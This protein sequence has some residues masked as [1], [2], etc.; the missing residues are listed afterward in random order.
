MPRITYRLMTAAAVAAIGLG[1]VA[2]GTASAEPTA[3][4]DQA[5]VFAARSTQ[6]KF[7]NGTGCT[8]TRA[9]HGLSHGIWSQEPPAVVYN[10]NDAEW[11]SESNGFMTGTEGSVKFTTSDCEEGWRS[12]RVIRFHWNNPYVGGNGYDTDGTDGSFR[13]VIEGGGGNNAVVR[14]GEYKN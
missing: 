8:L 9:D 6:V 3:S 2:A 12:G 13:N 14:W 10:T 7:H 4:A 1:A 5:V 11:R